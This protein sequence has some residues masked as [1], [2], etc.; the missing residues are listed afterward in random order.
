MSQVHVSRLSVPFRMPALGL[1]LC[2]MISVQVGAAVARKVFDEASPPGIV[3]LRLVFG[4]TALLI[5]S[6]KAIRVR[7]RREVAALAAFAATL[8]CMNLCFYGSIDRIPLGIAV[9]LEFLGPLTVAIIGSRR[10]L[11]VLWVVLA[12]AGVALLSGTDSGS[13]NAVGVALALTAGALWAVYIV[14]SARVGQLFQGGS[15]LAVAMAGAAVIAAPV[16]ITTGG[17]HLLRP[18]VLAIGLAV[19]VLSSAIPWS[20]ELEAL[21]RIPTHVFGVL[22]SLEPAL[23]ALAGVAVLGQSLHAL[24]AF[25]IVLV[26]AA[27][28]GAAWS[29]RLAPVDVV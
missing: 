26:I 19:G 2:S 21:R 13:M 4:S 17:S 3:L 28:A 29:S 25:A 15:G 16:G 20:F 22:M 12:A 24:T 11:D 23:A 5:V 18:H 1:V 6:R 27:S 14:L 9:T 7:S 8:G 10:A